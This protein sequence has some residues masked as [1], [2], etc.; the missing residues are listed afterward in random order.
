MAPARTTWALL[1]CLSILIFLQ[2]RKSLCVKNTT[3]CL[4]FY[5][6]EDLSCTNEGKCE[7]T[8]DPCSPPPC[9]QSAICLISPSGQTYK[10]RCPEGFGGADCDVPLERC[11]KNQCRHGGECYMSKGDPICVCASGYKGA[12]C[13]VPEDECVYNPCLNGAMC[14]DRGNGPSC[15]CVPGFQ[16]ALCD[17]EVDECASQPCRHGATCLNQI[18]RYTC[19]CPPE[20]TGT[21][22]ELEFNECLSVPCM[23]GA[24]CHHSPDSFFC[25]CLPGFTGDFCDL[26][27]DECASSPCLNGGNC[28]DGDNGYVCECSLVGFIG[29][30]CE[31]PVQPC[32]SQP[33]QNSA[34]CIE[35]SGS[36]TCVCWPGYT[37]SLCDTDIKECSSQPCLYGSEC[38]ELSW[39]ERHKDGGISAGYICKCGKGLTGVHCENDINECE[40]NP[41]QNRGIC[42]N[43][44]GSYICHCSTKKDDVGYYYGGRNCEELLLGCK[45]HTCQNGGSCIPH[46]IDGKQTHSCLCPAGFTDPACGTLTTFSFNG[47]AILPFKNMT[48]QLQGPP[49]NIYLSF[50][51]VQTSAVIFHLQ[52]QEMS[53]TLYLQNGYLL[54]A[55]QRQVKTFLQVAYNVSEDHWHAIEVTITNTLTLKLLDTSCA[56]RCSAQYVYVGA[57]DISFQSLLLGGEPPPETEER[58][59]FD[60]SVQKRP[61]FVGCIRDVRVDS[62]FLKADSLMLDNIEIGCKRHNWCRSDPC[63]NRGRC[64]NLW[65]SYQCE[66]Y[67]PYRGKDCSLEYETVRFG[68]EDMTSY[69]AFEH[70][71]DQSDDI[72]ISALFRTRQ[73][74]GLLLALGNTTSY[75]FFVSLEDG[76]LKVE[77]NGDLTLKGEHVMND[78]NVYL[79]SL[80]MVQHRLEIFVSL[81]SQGQISVDVQRLQATHVLYVGGLEDPMETTL[82]GGYFKGC[83][84]DLRIGN[85]QLEFFPSY[86]NPR[87]QILSNVME[88]CASDN[89]CKSSLCQNGGV[90]SPVWDDFVCSCP[91]NTTGRMCENVNWCQLHPCPHGAVCHP[92]PSGYECLTRAV[93]SSGDQFTF[94]SNGKI[95]RDLTNLT[96]GF[97]THKSDSVLFHA[98]REPE[99]I[100]LAICNSQVLFHLQ[101]GNSFYYVSLSGT[102]NV[103]DGQWHNVTLSMTAP[104]SQSSSWQLAVDGQ[105]D[106]ITSTV[107]TGNLNFL[108]EGTD[109]FL[110]APSRGMNMS[111]T[112]CLG[113]VRVGGIHLPYFSNTDYLTVKPQ[114]EQ[115]VKISPQSVVIGCLNADPCTPCPCNHG[116]SCLDAYTHA[117]CMCP[118]GLTGALCEMPIKY[119]LSNPCVHGN[120]TDGASGYKCECQTGYKG[121]NCN[122]SSC[123][124]HQCAN[125]ATCIGGTNGYSC[126]CPDSFTGRL[127]RFNRLPSTFCGNEKKN[128]TCYNYSNCTEVGGELRCVCLPGFVGARCGIDID[129]CISDPCLNGGLCQN[130][131][132]RFHCMCDVNFAGE[133]CEIDLSEFLPPGIFTAVASVV[134]ALFFVVCAGLCIFIAVAGMRSNQGTYSPSRQEKEGSRVEMWN[135]VQQP[136]LE[137]LI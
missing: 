52:G 68:H 3:R 32:L 134:L 74:S 98:E 6:G 41:C 38:L 104:G 137:R 107:A 27:V 97:R 16:G 131:P 135:I 60:K 66:C 101:S 11:S 58:G 118:P 26:N 100:T 51:T 34:T 36:F 75:N 71:S 103:S 37:G 47:T 61:W 44:H 50:R 105:M 48:S 88:G 62:T 54:L 42:E 40:L 14:R 87:N 83:V 132:G 92:V 91:Q 45:E 70:R 129:E 21:D 64:I 113:T 89:L 82:R 76:K 96:L 25:S 59:G 80:K 29:L 12:L 2:V 23:N 17:I 15:Y 124:D 13:E 130:L 1:L 117:Y 43:L 109:I 7:Q 133:R 79:V 108:R 81:Q 9:P 120:C 65:Q 39:N 57:G 128:I 126:L 20:Y 112:G 115:F 90:C 94:R 95:M 53:L 85:Q 46:L 125:G 106:K 111:F 102:E 86:S 28:I 114:P 110:G 122:I 63:Q 116:G 18:G 33:C 55:S 119:C 78:G 22:C 127:C 69:A 72:T 5:C 84:Q 121:E 30:H 123:H 49:S 31:T 56:D 99:S 24:T 136:P 4:S 10:C 73:P 19:V 93:F 8:T 35:D 67:R 77:T